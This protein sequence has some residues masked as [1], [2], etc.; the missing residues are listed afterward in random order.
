MLVV[1]PLEQFSNHFMDD[2]HWLQLE[3]DCQRPAILWEAAGLFVSKINVKQDEKAITDWG[4]RLQVKGGAIFPKLS[5]L[6]PAAPSFPTDIPASPATKPEVIS[7]VYNA[8]SQR[9]FIF[10][11]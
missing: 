11:I 6:S 1:V 4:I 10:S 2:G 8:T 7:I 3:P 5:F 9:G